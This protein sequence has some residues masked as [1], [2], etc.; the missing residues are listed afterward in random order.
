MYAL[1]QWRSRCN[2]DIVSIQIFFQLLAVE[3]IAAKNWIENEQSYH[4]KII[5]AKKTE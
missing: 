1:F 3:K 5:L 4:L 2:S